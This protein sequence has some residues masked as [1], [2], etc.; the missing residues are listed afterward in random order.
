MRWAVAEGLMGGFD[1][2]SFRGDREIQRGQF[3][4]IAFLTYG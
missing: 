3:A 4:L 1:D 2:G